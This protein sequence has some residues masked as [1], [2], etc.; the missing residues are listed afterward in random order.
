[1]LKLM[2][3]PIIVMIALAGMARQQQQ[4][5]FCLFYLS[6]EIKINVHKLDNQIKTAKSLQEVKQIILKSIT[7]KKGNVIVVFKMGGRLFRWERIFGPKPKEYLDD[8]AI[9]GT[10]GIGVIKIVDPLKFGEVLRDTIVIIDTFKVMA[11]FNDPSFPVENYKMKYNCGKRLNIVDIQVASKKV[12]LFLS[13]PFNRCNCNFSQVSL[14]NF[15]ADSSSLC[16]FSVF[17][18]TKETLFEWLSIA[19]QLKNYLPS[20]D[21][22]TIASYMTAYV[23]RKYGNCS[24]DQM[25]QWLNKRL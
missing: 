14:Y 22:E 23:K 4:S 10:R 18:P 17:T 20:P 11:A 7:D 15:Y 12:L 5:S 3:T 13:K 16:S 8:W 2:L 1:M 19:Q 21:M 24:P 25:E 6:N 9:L